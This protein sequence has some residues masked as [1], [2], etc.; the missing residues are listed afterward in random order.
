MKEFDIEMIK[1]ILVRDNTKP[2]NNTIRIV[3]NITKT[4]VQSGEMISHFNP[5]LKK[6]WYNTKSD[7]SDSSIEAIKRRYKEDKEFGYW[8]SQSGGQLLNIMERLDI[9][10][11]IDLGC[12]CGYMLKAMRSVEPIEIFGYDNEQVLIDIACSK[13]TLS[14]SDQEF[15][16]KDILTL[17]QSDIP[18][19]S[20]IYWWEPIKDKELC[21]KF[22][23]NICNISY[24]NQIIVF[25]SAAYSGD[26][27]RQNKKVE[28]LYD[29]RNNYRY[30][31]SIY[32]KK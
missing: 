20:L 14:Q 6:V 29:I 8:V 24:P 16:L 1:S 18:Q 28:C 27:M 23:D 26:F 3:D 15:K 13:G 21:E 19:N 12:G 2:E 10:R 31:F 11:I 30:P 7:N 4:L 9:S 17:K 32:I 5:E 25:T 22:I